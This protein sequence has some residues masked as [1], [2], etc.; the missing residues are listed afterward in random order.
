MKVSFYFV[1]QLVLSIVDD[2]KS[3]VEI[4]YTHLNNR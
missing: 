3:I 4:I 2:L 1:F